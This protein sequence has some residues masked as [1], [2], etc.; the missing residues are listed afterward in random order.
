MNGHGALIKENIRGCPKLP[1]GPLCPPLMDHDG[2]VVSLRN[3][4]MITVFMFMFMF[5]A[6]RLS[7]D[8]VNIP[9]LHPK[10]STPEPPHASQSTKPNLL[11]SCRATII[12]VEAHTQIRVS[13]LGLGCSSNS[14]HS[15]RLET[16]SEVSGKVGCSQDGER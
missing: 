11:A 2:P 10:P 13:G 14:R 4:Y 1:K 5:F 9:E 6:I 15:G 7:V 12:S 8:G 3:P 16:L